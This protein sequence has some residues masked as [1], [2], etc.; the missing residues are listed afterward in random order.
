MLAFWGEGLWLS[1]S[2]GGIGMM[3]RIGR[4]GKVTVVSSTKVYAVREDSGGLFFSYLQQ[5]Q[6]W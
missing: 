5:S 4:I 2:L 1:E 6:A 3:G